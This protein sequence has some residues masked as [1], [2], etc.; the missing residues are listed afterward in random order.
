MQTLY[1]ES[2]EVTPGTIAKKDLA[3]PR[4]ACREAKVPSGT[5]GHSTSDV[6][7]VQAALSD[8]GPARLASALGLKATT[9]GKVT[10]FPCPVHGGRDPNCEL[11][12]RDGRL[13]YICRSACGGAG[14]DA[15]SLIAAVEGLDP[16]RDF[17]AV[18]DRAAEL[19]GVTLD[20]AAGHR[21]PSGIR[22]LD[23]AARQAL[24]AEAPKPPPDPEV[25]AQQAAARW[26]LQSTELEGDAIPWLSRRRLKSPTRALLPA[27]ELGW[28][29][30]VDSAATATAYA[31]ANP[32]DADRIGKLIAHHRLVMPVTSAAG[33]VVAVQLRNI[34]PDCPKQYRFRSLGPTGLGFHNGAA[35]A[36]SSWMPVVLVEGG[37]D[38]LALLS[39]SEELRR[40]EL[41]PDA[42][43]GG[44]TV[45]GKAGTGKLTEEQAAQLRGRRVLIGYDSDNAGKAGITTAAESLRG[46]A[47]KVEAL[48]LPDDGPKDWAE[49]LPTEIGGAQ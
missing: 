28:T 37:T 27:V 13:L 49:W 40:S 48:L 39:W 42:L 31:A 33:D 8:L 35:L 7:R 41:C 32:T 17:R 16:R 44:F 18:L 24:R 21:V 11:T 19:A 29:F 22:A 4:S 30:V 43:R 26:L 45:V 34:S 20:G 47:R 38:T 3:I 9:R 46:V 10:R 2:G 1:T 12:D 5:F 15:L 14:G 36:Q 23:R 6:D 25:T